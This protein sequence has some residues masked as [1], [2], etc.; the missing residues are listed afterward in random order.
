MTAHTIW[1][2]RSKLIDN[3]GLHFVHDF[4]PHRCLLLITVWITADSCL[5]VRVKW[6]EASFV[7]LDSIG[8]TGFWSNGSF[9]EFL[10][11]K[12]SVL[13]IVFWFSF[14]CY[15]NSGHINNPFIFFRSQDADSS[16]TEM[17]DR[18]ESG[19][20]TVSVETKPES[21]TTSKS[22]RD[23]DPFSIPNP[24]ADLHVTA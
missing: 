5:V 8:K 23:S 10:P 21:I 11:I 18:G 24:S 19:T 20:T 6:S 14:L 9:A 22:L 15:W 3:I 16:V 12:K 4:I 1:S 7:S 2:W 17:N 13:L